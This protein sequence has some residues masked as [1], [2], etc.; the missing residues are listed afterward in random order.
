MAIFLYSLYYIVLVSGLYHMLIDLAKL[1]YTLPV[2]YYI[3]YRILLLR[4]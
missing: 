1:A 4:Y 3:I 2:L